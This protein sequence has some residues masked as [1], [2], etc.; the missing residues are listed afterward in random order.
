MQRVEQ[1][2]WRAMT[3]RGAENEIPTH[4]IRP[5]N[6]TPASRLGGPE[7]GGGI[8]ENLL[9]HIFGDGEGFEIF[10]VLGYVG[11]A[12]AGPVCAEESFVGDLGE[13]REIFEELFG[14]DA[15]DVEIDIFVAAE[16]EEGGVH[17]EGTA[18]VGE[19]DF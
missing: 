7:G 11:D 14:R 5:P 10:D 6:Q 3:S 15:A 17:P 1:K 16:E 8:P 2:F 9:T 4:L 19:E 18:A 13:A 12:G